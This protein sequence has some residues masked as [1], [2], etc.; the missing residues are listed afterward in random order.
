MTSVDQTNFVFHVNLN[1]TT[2]NNRVPE[3]QC[4]FTLIPPMPVGPSHLLVSSQPLLGNVWPHLL[5]KSISQMFFP[6]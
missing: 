3:C 6:L 1:K 5:V 2:Y 4:A